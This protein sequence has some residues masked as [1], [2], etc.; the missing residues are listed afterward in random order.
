MK[1]KMPETLAREPIDPRVGM[2][3][4]VFL[5]ASM[6]AAGKHVH[7]RVRNISERGAL[8]DGLGLPPEGSAV[9]LR[10][11]SL[12]ASGQIA[13]RAGGQCGLRFDEPVHVPAW[14][15]RIGQAGQDRVDKL[16]QLAREDAISGLAEPAGSQPEDSLDRIGADLDG[17]CERLAEL[18]F[19]LEQS[20]ELLKLDAI[21]QRLAKLVATKPERDACS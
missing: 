21:A 16:V 11:G 18:P 12:N 5:N 14:V 3:S 15:R 7:V 19:S 10:R 6:V 4:N 20:E 8:V 2:R 1:R 17:I 13:W 9:Q